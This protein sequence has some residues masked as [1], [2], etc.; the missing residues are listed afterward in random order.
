MISDTLVKKLWEE[1]ADS[2]VELNK[3]GYNIYR[4]LVSNPAFFSI[5]PPVADLKCLDIGC[6]EG[7]GTRELARLGANVTGIDISKNMIN[8]AQN[9]EKTTP[10][11]IKYISCSV[12]N[13]PFPDNSFDTVTAF[14]SLMDIQ[15]LDK[16]LEEISR[17]MKNDGFLQFSI[18]HPCFW[19]QSNN[20]I[21]DDDGKCIG[22]QINSYFDQDHGKVNEWNFDAVDTEEELNLPTFK[23]ALFKRTFS[24][25]IAAL[26]KSG[27]YVEELIEP[28]ASLEAVAKNP[29]MEPSR[30]FPFFMVL[31]CRLLE[32]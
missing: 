19:D 3:K 26:Q 1:N 18:T 28:Q 22:V 15:N 31:R 23:T 27:F 7:T 32:K 2:W 5:L 4:D 14:C 21:N 30:L 9:I 12:L 29:S 17:V 20:W 10:L 16:A 11:G 6:G 25:W 13:L 8:H 24:Q